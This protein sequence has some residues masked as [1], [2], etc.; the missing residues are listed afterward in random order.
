M[1]ISYQV[2]MD[3]A[4]HSFIMPH[5][6]LILIAV[7]LLFLVVST[8][9]MFITVSG[10]A[11]RNEQLK[12]LETENKNLRWKLDFYAATVDSIYQ[13][14]DT[15]QV[16]ISKDAKDYPALDLKQGSK[17]K[18]TFEPAL[19]EK[20]DN[21]EIKLATI[22]TA[23]SEP[24]S[25]SNPISTENTTDEFI[26]SIYPTFGRI[27][28]GW[29][30]RVHPIYNDIEFHS[31]MDIANQTGT[32]VYATA[33]GTV[34]TTDYDTN[35]GKRIK[36]DHGNGYET[37]YAHLYSYMVQSGEQVIK[38]QIIGLIGTSG[39]ST[40][41]HLHYEVHLNQEKVNPVA[42]LNRIEEPLYAL[43]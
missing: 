28:D 20:M 16:N 37:L 13:R 38:G 24:A 34:I 12:R 9:I 10:N 15:L 42:Y 23:I 21:L 41:P 17:Q 27:S 36:I 39:L 2:G 43:R 22:L 14:L 30:L 18:V 40:G 7:L 5:Y 32:P 25:A 4:K 19:R 35:Y 26:P 1:Q 11:S 33:A 29:G 6:A 31:G 8:L 3:G